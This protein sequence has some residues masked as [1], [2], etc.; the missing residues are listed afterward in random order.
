MWGNVEAVKLLINAGADVNAQN[1]IAQMAPLHSAVRGTF[2]SFAQT[3]T[4][5]LE[6]VKMLLEAN[7]DVTLKDSKGCDP[8]Q[9]IDDVIKES[10]E[11]DLGDIEAEM[12]E[13][14]KVFLLYSAISVSPIQQS[15]ENNDMEGVKKALA[16]TANPVSQEEKNEMLLKAVDKIEYLI[17][18][19]IDEKVRF[20]LY[21]EMATTLL[22]NGAN[23]N[24]YLIPNESPQPLAEAPLHILC[25][26]LTSNP[27]LPS[28]V[29]CFAKVVMALREKGATVCQD[30]CALLP[31]LAHR[32]NIR[33]VKLLIEVAGVDVN[34]KGR[35]DMT[36][37]IHASRG[38]K[39]DIVEYLL[40]SKDLDVGAQDNR[41]KT[42]LDYAVANN[43]QAVV[44]L[45]Q[46]R[47]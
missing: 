4:R 12:A 47:V 45:L 29:D 1:V 8:F 11:R 38:G 42:A 9:T 22:Q 35:Q 17:D 3:H 41:G 6:C 5:R 21:G 19:Q 7:A 25:K 26:S 13:M 27:P 46:T 15:I 33:L 32:G 31:T 36:C 20:D 34:S 18:N 14:K 2:Q 39:I 37:L 44:E 23:P 28:A 43:K 24:S 16:D 40:M 10:N 30:T